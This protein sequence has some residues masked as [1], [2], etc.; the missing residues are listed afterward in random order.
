MKTPN[1]EHKG[2]IFMMCYLSQFPKMFHNTVTPFLIDKIQV[3]NNG[4]RDPNA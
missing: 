1:V 3:P 2:E 4:L